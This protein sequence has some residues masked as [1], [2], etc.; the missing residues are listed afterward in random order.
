MKVPPVFEINLI[1]LLF[2]FFTRYVHHQVKE[3]ALKWIGVWK[4]HHR[5]EMKRKDPN[6]SFWDWLRSWNESFEKLNYQ[7]GRYAHCFERGMLEMV[8]VLKLNTKSSW[9]E[10]FRKSYFFH[11]WTSQKNIR[12]KGEHG[13][14]KTDLTG[15]SL[16]WTEI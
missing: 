7:D 4:T 13:S 12:A 11:F 2:S 14:V 5:R 1:F 10:V 6:S 15:I 8:R 16:K 3:I 9:N